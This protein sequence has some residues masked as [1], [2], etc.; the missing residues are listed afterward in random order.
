M[1]ICWAVRVAALATAG[2]I[3]AAGSL[4]SAASAP[5]TFSGCAPVL[6]R[7]GLLA[8]GPYTTQNFVPGMRV[9]V[10]AGGWRSGEDSINEFRL[11]PPAHPDEHVRFWLDPHASTPCTDKVLPVVTSTP[12]GIVRWLRANSNVIVSAARQT[13]IAGGIAATSVDLDVSRRAPRCDPA[14]PGPCID[15]FLFRVPGLTEPFGTGLGSRVRLYF[16][17]IGK[18]HHLLAVAVEASNSKEFAPLTASA[19]TILTHL[20]LP[21]KLPPKRR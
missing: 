5:R 10:P 18:P 19:T 13:T 14:C 17:P 8:V 12:S 16:A 15:Y 6:C 7:P 4:A 9:T 20:R 2:L 3:A 1:V 21:A 11:E